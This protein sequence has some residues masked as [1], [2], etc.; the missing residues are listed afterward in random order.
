MHRK[1]LAVTFRCSTLMRQWLPA[2][3]AASEGL[4]VEEGWRVR[5]DGSKFM[6]DVII[7]AVCDESGKLRGFSKITRDITERKQAEEQTILELEHP[8]KEPMSPSMTF[9]N[10]SGWYRATRSFSPSDTRISSTTRPKNSSLR[11]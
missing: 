2:I 6:A 5:K 1:S 10:R 11:R 7:T 3:L 4:Y 9:R 8:N